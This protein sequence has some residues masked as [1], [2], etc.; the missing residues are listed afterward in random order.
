MGKR[1]DKFF[2]S[3]LETNGELMRTV[4]QSDPEHQILRHAADLYQR[5]LNLEKARL[6]GSIIRC[7]FS[8][9]SIR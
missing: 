3:V 2:E 4:Y 9:F 8:L 1:L 5:H 6:A 7:E